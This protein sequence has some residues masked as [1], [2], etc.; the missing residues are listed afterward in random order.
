MAPP[1]DMD[2]LLEAVALH[3]Y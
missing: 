1:Q 3:P 2:V